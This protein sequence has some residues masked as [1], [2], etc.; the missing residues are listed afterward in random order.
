MCD[1]TIPTPSDFL[2][3]FDEGMN[4]TF[5]GDDVD[6]PVQEYILIDKTTVELRLDV[7]GN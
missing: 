7:T 1:G 6:P 3:L 2:I 4:V 5:S